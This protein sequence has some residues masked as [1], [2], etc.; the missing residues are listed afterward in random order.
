MSS[1]S[2][3]TSTRD[4]LI[5]HFIPR[6]SAVP[7]QGPTFRACGDHPHRRS[8]SREPVAPRA[9]RAC[10]SGT[11]RSAH[12]SGSRA[13]SPTCCCWNRPRVRACGSPAAAAPVPAAAD[14][15]REHRRPERGDASARRRRPRDEAVPPSQLERALEQALIPT[16]ERGLADRT[17][18]GPDAA[19]RLRPAQRRSLQ[20]FECRASG[21]ARTMLVLTRT[22]GRGDPR[23]RRGRGASARTAAFGSRRRRA[24]TARR[25]SS[26]SSRR[27]RQAGDEIVQRRRC[28]VFLDETAA[29]VLADKTLDVHAHGDHFHFSIDEQTSRDRLADRPGLAAVQQRRE[30]ALAALLGRRRDL[31]GHQLVVDRAAHVAEDADRRAAVRLLRHARERERERRPT[32]AARR[33][34]ARPSSLAPQTSI[35]PSLRCRSAFSR[36]APQRIGSPSRSDDPV[37]AFLV[38]AHEVERVVVED[39]AVLEDLDERA[40]AMLRPRRAA[41]RSSPPCRCRSR[42]RRTSPPRRSRATAG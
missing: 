13:R 16:A 8:G 9:P 5:P 12:A 27:S 37:H 22:G 34:R 2:S 28:G 19:W 23:D 35:E 33:A 14:P 20:G 17:A 15:L 26:S 41:P 6:A 30:I 29:A 24:T 4:S 40:A 1:S 31:L 10:G 25:R 21:Y 18:A 42:A 3:T 38:V 39:R 11:A 32:R 7:S 36:S